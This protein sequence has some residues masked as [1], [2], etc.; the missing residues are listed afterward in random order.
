MKNFIQKV[1]V[2]TAICVCTHVVAATCP[3]PVT[4]MPVGDSITDGFNGGGLPVR[5]ERVGYRQGLYGDLSALYQ[6]DFVGSQQSGSLML[7]AFDVD[8]EGHGGKTDDWVAERIFSWLIDNPADYLLLHI[9]TNNPQ[10]S[11]ADVERILNNVDRFSP[12]THVVV[13]RIINTRNGSGTVS[14]FNNNVASMVLARIAGGDKLSIVDMESA[15]NYSTDMADS[16]HPNASGYAKMKDVW[17]TEMDSLLSARCTGAPVFVS[18][19]ASDTPLNGA[20]QYQVDVTG[21]G[22][23]SYSLLSAPTGMSISPGGML[24]WTPSST[25]AYNISIQATGPQGSA[26][27]DFVLSVENQIILDTGDPGTS[28]IGTWSDSLASN[29]YGNI[30]LFS[31]SSTASYTYQMNVTGVHEVAVWWTHLL[32]RHTAVPVDIYDGTTLL[33]TVT[34]D[35]LNSGGLGWNSL[36]YYNFNGSAKVVVRSVSGINTTSVDAVK[37]RPVAEAPPAI[38]SSPVTTATTGVPY[39][40]H[41]MA[42][43]APA[44]TFSLSV[45]PSGMS[46]DPMTGIISWVPAVT[47]TFSVQVDSSNSSGIDSQNFNIVVSQPSSLLIVDNGDPGTSFSGT[48]SPSSGPTPFSADSLYSKSIGSTYT[49]TATVL[50]TYDVALWWTVL[51]NRETQVPV[52]IYDGNVLLDTVMVNQSVNGGQWNTIGNYN[53]TSGQANIVILVNSANTT[54]ADA[55]RLSAVDISV[56]SIT[57]TAL[58]TAITGNPYSYDV[59]AVSNPAAVFSLVTSPA[60]MSIDPGTGLISWTPG[61]A[62]TFNMDV[63]AANANGF[64][65]QAFTITVNDPGLEV[66][67]DNGDPGTS[68]VGSW[69]TSSG[70]PSYGNMSVF[71]QV[72]GSGYTFTAPVVGSQEVAIWWT[73]HV[74]RHNAVPVDIYDD[75]NLLSTVIVNQQSGGGQWNVLGSYNFSGTARVV[76][77]SVSDSAATSADAV[78][79]QQVDVSI[80]KISTTP[81]TF[82]VTGAAYSYDV[83]AMGNPIPDLQLTQSPLGMTIDSVTGLIW[84]TPAAAG[85][86]PVEVQASNLNGSDLQSFTITVTDPVPEVIVD[87]GDPGTSFSGSWSASSGTPA[88]GTDSLFNQT[89]GS[90]Y[91][92]DA[93]LV[94]GQQVYLWWTNHANRYSAVPVDIYDGAALMATVIVDQTANGGR[95]NLLGSY[96]F[97]GQARVVVRS[98][99]S[100]AATCVDAVKFVTADIAVPQITTTALTTANVGMLYSY[101]VDA[102]GTPTLF[103]SLTASPTGMTIDANGLINWTPPSAGSFNVSVRVSNS[104][105]SDLQNFTITVSAPSTELIIDNGDPGTSAVGSWPVSGGANPYGSVSLYSKNAGDSYTYSASAGGLQQVSV[106]WTDFANRETAVPIEIYD[107]TTLLDTVLVNQVINGGQW[108]ILGNYTFNSQARIVI[109]AVSSNSTCADAVRFVAQ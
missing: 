1:I 79:L 16:L 63:H 67:V 61:L 84:W 31:S 4:I 69:A 97:T 80:P 101:N 45:A 64:D 11:P 39:S 12:N 72:A 75:L 88:Y 103:Y 7:P 36:G 34:V 77:R 8:H 106:W 52:E 46:I 19:S 81:V 55:V 89:P 71:N 102:I 83:D 35:Q 73:N 43:G 15:L 82:A 26:T 29:F 58:T 28:S 42:S 90:S 40:Y 20:Y 74:N 87:N 62:G 18:T 91:T 57:S 27:Q 21:A 56:P 70:T 65:S 38:N 108:N 51:A 96:T 76:I 22:P 104:S 23:V 41:V 107:G 3:R 92:Y 59:A 9:G 48:W 54:C 60:G 99:S 85:S 95:W 66:I 13:A 37:L 17:K 2:F 86:Y 105:G 33:A 93:T 32:N 49:Y 30:S 78:R 98:V 68:A 6:V 50:G 47:G 10:T 44:P 24:S 100:V 94:G 109:N 53:F 14:Q 5:D 25:G